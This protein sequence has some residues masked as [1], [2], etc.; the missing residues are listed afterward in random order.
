MIVVTVLLGALTAWLLVP[1]DPAR[2]WQRLS[3][4]ASPVEPTARRRFAAP[5]LSLALLAPVPGFLLF[6]TTGLAA[7]LAATMVIATVGLVAVRQRRARRAMSARVEVAH[8]AEVVASLVKVGQ[9]PASALVAAAKDCPVLAR[10]AAIQQVGGEPSSALRAD[11][12][13]PGAH[14][15][16]ALAQA[17]EVSATTGAPMASSLDAVVDELREARDLA[18]LVDG[19]LAA[20]R[21]TGQLLGALPFAG[22]GFGAL[23]GG[24]PIG[25]LMGSMLGNGCLVAGVGLA[26]AGVLWSDVLAARA[27]SSVEVA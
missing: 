21:A 25:F 17:W 12:A 19:E 14:G 18:R 24:D 1:P 6:G 23:L 4:A 20:P 26:C 3:I 22:L 8:A 9:I 10:S 15:L 27:A 16:V 5:V 2:L 7:A 11:G 13:M